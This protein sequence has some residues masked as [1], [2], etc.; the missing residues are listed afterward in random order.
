MAKSH[1]K[2]EQLKQKLIKA[3]VYIVLYSFYLEHMGLFKVF[4]EHFKNFISTHFIQFLG[5]NYRDTCLYFG[6][7]LFSI[8]TMVF[9]NALIFD[10]LSLN[11]I[12]LTHF[13]MSVIQF[14]FFDRKFLGSGA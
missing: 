7:L 12:I 1:V 14:S 3:L 4:Q 10:F 11:I 2:P 6:K 8:S 9:L 5:F 13:S